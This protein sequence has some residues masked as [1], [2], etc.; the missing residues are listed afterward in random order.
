MLDEHQQELARVRAEDEAVRLKA[1]EDVKAEA[2][3]R[4]D[5]IQSD[6]LVKSSRQSAAEVEILREQ[7]R[8]QEL[9]QQESQKQITEALKQIPAVVTAHAGGVEG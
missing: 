8:E 2:Q 3:R 7:V 4:H 5:E 9:R 1:I 6:A